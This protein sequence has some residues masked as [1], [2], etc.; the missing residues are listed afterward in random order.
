MARA[1]VHR[2][3]AP[4]K[5]IARRGVQACESDDQ[6]R[7]QAHFQCDATLQSVDDA[8][9][10]V[11]CA[12]NRPACECKRRAAGKGAGASMRRQPSICRWSAGLRSKVTRRGVIP[13]LYLRCVSAVCVVGGPYR[14]KREAKYMR[15]RGHGFRGN[16][17]FA[18]RHAPPRRVATAL[19]Q[20]AAGA[21]MG[22]I[23]AMPEGRGMRVR[24]DTVQNRLVRC[25]AQVERHARHI[26]PPAIGK[27]TLGLPGASA[28]SCYCPSVFSG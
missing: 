4:A 16:L 11:S 24:Q 7:T 20:Y 1:N 3:R 21:S 14:G 8:R 9:R 15:R 28:K 12:A 27:W 10:A 13:S 23:R 22:R 18:G 26:K 2:G 19:M 6:I 5:G 17:G 25:A